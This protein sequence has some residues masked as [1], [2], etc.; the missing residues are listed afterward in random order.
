MFKNV[1]FHCVGVLLHYLYVVLMIRDVFFEY[2][3]DYVVMLVYICVQ[4]RH[5][6]GIFYRFNTPLT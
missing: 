6:L 4:K 5:I 2:D 3:K 1:Y